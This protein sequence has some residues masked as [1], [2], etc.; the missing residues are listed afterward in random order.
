MFNEDENTS[1]F[2]LK[3]RNNPPFCGLV[4]TVPCNFCLILIEGVRI[5]ENVSQA[6][7]FSEFRCLSEIGGVGLKEVVVTKARPAQQLCHLGRAK[8]ACSPHSPHPKGPEHCSRATIATRGGQGQENRVWSQALCDLHA[9]EAL[10]L[11][12]KE[13]ADKADGEVEV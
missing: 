2:C 1:A 12:G 8:E 4:P 5:L 10:D 6:A 13:V 9:R 11:A 7:I 3:I